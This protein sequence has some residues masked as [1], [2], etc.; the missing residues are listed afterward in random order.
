MQ[1]ST[2][3]NNKYDLILGCE[4]VGEGMI[5]HIDALERLT[6]RNSPHRSLFI[7]I[8]FYPAEKVSKHDKSCWH[9][10]QS[11]YQISLIDQ[12]LL[13]RLSTEVFKKF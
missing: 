4:I 6:L 9:L 5:R 3:F 10:I 2:C 12:L 7:P 11:L 13:G 8:R 1:I